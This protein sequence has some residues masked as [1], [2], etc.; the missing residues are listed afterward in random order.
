MPYRINRRGSG[1]GRDEGPVR[2]GSFHRR[3]I[4]QTPPPTPFHQRFTN[5][6]IITR[7]RGIRIETR[8]NR[9]TGELV[10]TLVGTPSQELLQ[11]HHSTIVA[12]WGYRESWPDFMAKLLRPRP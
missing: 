8:R 1:Y 9:V 6:L 7:Q 10:N 12:K 2:T 3:R 11:T 5:E 4:V